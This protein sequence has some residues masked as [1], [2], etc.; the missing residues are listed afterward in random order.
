MKKKIVAILRSVVLLVVLGLALVSTPFEVFGSGDSM[1]A[2]RGIRKLVQA[3]WIAIA[4]ISIETAIS[5][6]QALRRPK[7]EKGTPEKAPPPGG[8]ADPPEPT[9]S[10]K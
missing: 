10:A 5:W 6:F 4:W 7:A 2:V 3:T 1:V 9:S 8:A